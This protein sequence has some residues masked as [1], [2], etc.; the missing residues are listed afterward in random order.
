MSGLALQMKLTIHRELARRGETT[1]HT[2]VPWQPCTMFPQLISGCAHDCNVTDNEKTRI[3]GPGHLTWDKNDLPSLLYK[4]ETPAGKILKLS[5]LGNLL[6]VDA[7]VFHPEAR[8]CG[9]LSICCTVHAWEMRNVDEDN[10]HACVTKSTL[11]EIS[12]C[13]NPC[14]KNAVIYTRTTAPVFPEWEREFC[15]EEEDA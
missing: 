7:V 4:H 12:C 5:W 6:M 14:N 3:L 1:A 2:H 11:D 10:W 8:R 9:A 15:T 13:E